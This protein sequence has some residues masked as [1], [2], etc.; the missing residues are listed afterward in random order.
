MRRRFGFDQEVETCTGK[1]VPAATSASCA[2]D[3]CGD[4][5]VQSPEE[6]DDGNEDQTDGCTN[7]CKKATCGDGSVWKGHEACDDGNAKNDDSCTATC[8]AATCGDGFV[9]TGKETCDD[10]N[11][12]N[13]DS[14]TSAC[15]PAK[16]GDGI[17]WTGKET[18]DDKNTVN[19][20]SCSNAC[21]KAACGD[22]IVQSGEECDDKNT[23]SGDGCS[24][25]CTVEPVQIVGLVD[26]ICALGS[27]G[28]I[29]CFTAGA[30]TFDVTTV[31]L[32]SGVAATQIAGDYDHM[33]ALLGDGQVR[34]WGSNDAG[35]LGLSDNI[36]REFSS[37]SSNAPLG[38]GLAA[39]S[40]AVGD[41]H[42]CAVL[43]NGNTKCWGRSEDGQLGLQT[44][45]A[46]GDGPGE[47]GDNLPAIAS[48]DGISQFVAA[49]AATTC[50][51]TADKTA[52][53]YGWGTDY[54]LTAKGTLNLGSTS[55]V[56]NLA[57]ANGTFCAVL[58]DHS[59]KCWGNNS[60]GRLGQDDTKN[61]VLP[62]TMGDALKPI[63]LG[64]GRSASS[65]YILG[66]STFA[67]LDDGSIKAWGVNYG[68]ILGRGNNTAVGGHAGDMAALAPLPLPTGRK[69]KQLGLSLATYCA[70]LDDGSIACWGNVPNGTVLGDEPN[71]MG[72]KLPI[73]KLKF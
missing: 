20:D 72:D 42:T 41:S 31:P 67:I 43:S 37:L 39:R 45:E 49:G 28:Q 7:A 73:V 17:I 58:T 23:V 25:T 64:K 33:C 60:D 51:V 3:T 24:K 13:T 54:A 12:V 44:S 71:E 70:L 34:C 65:V 35:Q 29:R 30:T 63:N 18:C 47:M 9:W 8:V 10:K 46:L 15:I 48:V 56:L 11:T 27:N 5:K 50:V 21:Q 14:C 57:L 61:R 19:T 4:G 59:L 62:E 40:I 16:C 69:A 2:P 36:R 22:G 66:P 53:C 38:V 1:C 68:G 6:C 32:P 55:T 26:Q 52:H